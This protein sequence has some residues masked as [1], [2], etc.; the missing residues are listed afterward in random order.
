MMEMSGL[1]SQRSTMTGL[2]SK[3]RT[4]RMYNR[5]RRCE[6]L[7]HL[8]SCSQFSVAHQRCQCRYRVA[9]KSPEHQH[10]YVMHQS[11]QNKSA[12]KHVRNEQISRNSHLKNFR[13]RHDT[14]KQNSVMSNTAFHAI[15]SARVTT[16]CQH[17]IDA[18]ATPLLVRKFFCNRLP[19][20]PFSV[21]HIRVLLTAKPTLEKPFSIK[22]TGMLFTQFDFKSF[23][24]IKRH[25]VASLMTSVQKEV[26]L[27]KV[28]VQLQ[29]C[30]VPDIF[31]A[32]RYNS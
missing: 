23:Y 32:T 10:I 1:A 14:Y 6:N 2:S 20:H 31:C 18:S 15:G 17:P 26:F 21:K 8:N 9:Q 28:Y 16:L 22:S 25:S 4:H 13:I 11:S 24:V 7:T 3:P 30:K 27:C 5:C 12:E 29:L 19:L